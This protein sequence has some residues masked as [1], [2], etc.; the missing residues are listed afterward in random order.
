MYLTKDYQI[1][2]KLEKGN[3]I[4]GFNGNY[5]VIDLIENSNS[6]VLQRYEHWN[7]SQF[8]TLPNY[9]DFDNLIKVKYYKDTRMYWIYAKDFTSIE[10]CSIVGL[11]D[12]FITL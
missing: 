10:S 9:L 11:K 3:I 5:K 6:I 7:K 1:K 8:I 4:K 12:T 2:Y